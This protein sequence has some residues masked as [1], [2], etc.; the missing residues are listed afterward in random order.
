MKIV[1]AL[2]LACLGTFM[3]PVGVRAQQPSILSIATNGSATAGSFNISQPAGPG[4]QPNIIIINGDNNG[5]NTN[6]NSNPVPAAAQ[7]PPSL[8][9]VAVT[10]QQPPETVSFLQT[11]VV[12]VQAPVQTQFAFV[13]VAQQQQA[14]FFPVQQQFLPLA[15]PVAQPAI[16]PQAPGFLPPQ[17]IAPPPNPLPPPAVTIQAPP[18]PPPVVQTSQTVFFT[19]TAEPAKIPTPTPTS[20]I[21]PSQIQTVF[22]QAPESSSAVKPLTTSS[23]PASSLD[24]SE[25]PFRE[26]IV[27]Q[28]FNV[29]M[30]QT[31]TEVFRQTQTEVVKITQNVN[32]TRTLDPVADPT[33]EAAS[34]A[35]S[36][37]SS[38]ETVFVTVTQNYIMPSIAMSFITILPNNGADASASASATAFAEAF[39]TAGSVTVTQV[40]T[41]FETV[42][43]TADPTIDESPSVSSD[44]ES[45]SPP[46]ETVF[47]TMPY[48]AMPVS[49]MVLVNNHTTV[50]SIERYIPTPVYITVQA[51][52]YATA[53]AYATAY[54]EAGQDPAMTVTYAPSAIGPLSV[55]TMTPD[56]F[57]TT[58]VVKLPDNEPES[59]SPLTEDPQKETSIECNP[60]TDPHCQKPLTVAS[61]DPAT[62][63]DCLA[64]DTCL[65]VF[66]KDDC[67]KAPIG[68]ALMDMQCIQ[69]L[70]PRDQSVPLTVDLKQA[71][72][73]P[74]LN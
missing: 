33:P 52:A 61:C 51:E 26:E 22:I 17:I 73:I 30:N 34:V 53:N 68:N 19:P 18:P 32:I 69:I 28:L 37:S 12:T 56:I 49:S 44:S 29:T 60:L 10:V 55:Q 35:D 48:T 70:A 20:Q 54:A 2:I 40:V 21:P 24:S 11:M 74:Q 27:T 47:V 58:T 50:I 1:S 31:I 14:Q 7:I 8:T 66:Y 25:L 23:A 4:K 45:M 63:P 38:S 46:T 62:D 64:V 3:A 42:T 65:N 67:S 36:S 9:T 6:S 59:D 72:R 16:V 57:L 5:R 71:Y 39:A 43:V 13:P 41:Q 15:Q